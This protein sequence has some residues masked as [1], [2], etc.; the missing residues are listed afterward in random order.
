MTIVITTDGLRAH[1]ELSD[2]H[3]NPILDDLTERRKEDQELSKGAQEER[4]NKLKDASH[5]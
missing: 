3:L 4:I 2:K 5:E 1:F